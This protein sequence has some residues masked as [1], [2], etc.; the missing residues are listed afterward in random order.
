MRNLKKLLNY[1]E[2]NLGETGKEDLDWY[3]NYRPKTVSA[4]EFFNAYAWALLVSGIKRKA[5]E[6]WK[7]NNDFDSVFTLRNCRLNNSRDLISVC[8][9][10]AII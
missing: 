4:K 10:K 1:C 9:K 3:D 6:S 7:E 5:A 2:R 8:P